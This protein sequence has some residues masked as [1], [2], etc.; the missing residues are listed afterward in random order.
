[1]NAPDLR[2]QRDFSNVG[3]DEAL[4]RAHSLIPFLRKHA[5]ANDS[6]TRLVPEVVQAIHE[7]GLFRYLQPKRWG[8]MEL[9]FVSYFDVPEVLARG[10]IST[11]WVVA[12]LA[13]H[14]RGL[15]LWPEAAQEEIW[16]QSR[17]TLI[18]SGIAFFQ[19]TAKRVC[20][21][22]RLTG[23]W[24]F[25]SGVDHATWEQ[26]AC[27][28]KNEA[29]APVDWVMCQVPLG[30]CQVIDDWQTLGM[31]GTGSRTVVCDGVFVP[32]HRALSMHVAAR[33]HA[34]PG[35]KLHANPMFKVPTPAL[36]GHCIAGC[37]VGNAAAMLDL[38]T[39]M[40]KE[41]STA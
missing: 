33:S 3:I 20:G 28:V 19:G 11:A 9:D 7:A 36:G 8:G 12:N 40:V 38:A 35:L 5:S 6:A 15:A 25:S 2:Q 13:S 31:R 16:G 14:H 26:L 32:G 37:V 30:D 4:E 18:A 39:Q 22:L 10:D 23:K 17:D 29:G 34:Y 41:R 1:M 27:I 21:G 24:G